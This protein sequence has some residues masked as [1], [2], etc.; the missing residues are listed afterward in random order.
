MASSAID[1][2]VGRTNR[3]MIKPAESPLYTL[4]LIPRS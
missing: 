1:A 4:T 2:I 3:P